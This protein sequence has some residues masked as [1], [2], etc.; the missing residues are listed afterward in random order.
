LPPP[1]FLIYSTVN[2]LYLC[3]FESTARCPMIKF[4][5]WC[6]LFI[7][8][9]PVAIVALLLYPLVWLVSI[10]FRILGIAVDGLLELVRALVLL[11]ARL[12]RK[13]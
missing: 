3:V 10:P 2:R 8:C 12:L 7:L 5:F 13:L 1:Q 9:W 11:P 6:I 4:F